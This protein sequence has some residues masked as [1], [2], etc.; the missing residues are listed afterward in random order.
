[1]VSVAAGA[2]PNLVV[3]CC[4][5]VICEILHDLYLRISHAAYSDSG[6]GC[7][8]IDEIAPFIGL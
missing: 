8:G 7:L 1:M 6:R 5:A 2:G 3:G 4:L